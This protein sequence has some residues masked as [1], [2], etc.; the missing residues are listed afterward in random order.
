MSLVPIDEQ[1]KSK[2][3]SVVYKKLTED[4]TP[5]ADF[6]GLSHLIDDHQDDLD[7][8]IPNLALSKGEPPFDACWSD[9]FESVMSL[10][11]SST[12]L[13]RMFQQ[14]NRSLSMDD[15]CYSTTTTD[16]IDSFSSL[17]S[18]DQ[19]I[20][21]T[22]RSVMD[23]ACTLLAI[24][25]A[26]EQDVGVCSSVPKRLEEAKNDT[27]RIHSS[28]TTTTKQSPHNYELND[29]RRSLVR[30]QQSGGSRRRVTRTSSVDSWLSD[31][32]VTTTQGDKRRSMPSRSHLGHC[33]RPVVSSLEHCDPTRSTQSKE[34]CPKSRQS[35]PSGTILRRRAQSISVKAGS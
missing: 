25:L 10:Q 6:F 15:S 24:D 28:K 1:L 29:Q 3:V 30:L 7:K 12:S 19:G 23:D 21:D 34:S 16:F 32:Q 17:A 13:R 9:K 5:S 11:S 35:R 33:H 14:S 18:S 22:S 26:D 2:A 4:N 31:N 20:K 27:K 8:S